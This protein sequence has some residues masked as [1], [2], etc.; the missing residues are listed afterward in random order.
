MKRSVNIFNVR[1]HYSLKEEWKEI[2][3]AGNKKGILSRRHVLC[4]NPICAGNGSETV[5]WLYILNWRM[6]KSPGCGMLY[7]QVIYFMPYVLMIF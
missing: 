4:F 1:L 6:I 5:H 7:M 2:Q 3:K